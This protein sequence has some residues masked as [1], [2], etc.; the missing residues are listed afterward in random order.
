MTIIYCSWVCNL[1]GAQW[2]SLTSASR[3]VTWAGFT[4]TGGSAFKMAHSPGGRLVLAVSWLLSQHWRLGASICLPIGRSMWPVLPQSMVAVFQGWVSKETELCA[5]CVAFYD[6]D[7]AI[8]Q[9]HFCHI[10]EL[11][12]V[13]EAHRFRGKGYRHH[14]LMQWQGSGTACGMKNIVTILENTFCHI[15]TPQ[16]GPG[17]V[18]GLTRFLS[19]VLNPVFLD[20]NFILFFLCRLGFSV[21]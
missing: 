3:G 14:L 17:S 19:G 11:W 10:L 15:V 2:G 16:T 1:H 12:A 9:H 18:K 13:T 5:S 4:G 20:I 21:L 8:T 6:L 7:S